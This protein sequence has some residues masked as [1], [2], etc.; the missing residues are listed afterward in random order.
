MVSR[1]TPRAVVSRWTTERVARQ[2]RMVSEPT[3]G[4][5]RVHRA[6]GDGAMCGGGSSTRRNVRTMAP[7]LVTCQDCLRLSGRNEREAAWQPWSDG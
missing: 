3:R 1:V 4:T 2:W 6:R 5:E 7:E